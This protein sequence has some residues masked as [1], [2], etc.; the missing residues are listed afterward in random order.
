[1]ADEKETRAVPG[2]VWLLWVLGIG[3]LLAVIASSRVVGN[4]SDSRRAKASSDLAEI[5]NALDRFRLA[6][7]RYPSNK[8]GLSVLVVGGTIKGWNGPYLAAPKLDP[9]SNPYVY[10]DLGGE[11][12]SVS[13]L[14][15]DGLPGGKGVNEDIE[16]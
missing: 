10:R 12:V 14:G 6:C 2:V 16:R 8:E 1:M 11:F 15:A 13:S 4:S 3:S 7:D 9:W 5:R